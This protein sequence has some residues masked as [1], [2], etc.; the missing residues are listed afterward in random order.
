MRVVRVHEFGTP[1]VL[2][3]EQAQVPH[4]AAGQVVIA[5]ELAGVIYGDVIVR[6]GRYPFPL[7]YVPGLEVGGRVIEVGADVDPS[8]VGQ[9]VVATTVGM[10]GGYAELAVADTANVHQ[11]P[12]SLPLEHAVAVFQ[13]GGLSVGILSAMQVR[14]EDTV[15]VTAA[16]G[17][18]GSVLVQLAKAA[19]AK[20]V[21]AAGG[22]EKVVAA[23]SRFGADTAVDYSEPDWV[24]QV[25]AATGGRGADVVLDAIGGTIGAQ[26][27]DAVRNGSGRI[28]IY[29]FT[30]GSW[31]ALDAFQL[32]RRGLTVVGALGIAFAKPT[33]EQR[34]D[35]EQA[36]QAASAGQLLPHIHGIYPLEQ[37]A[38]AQSA[39]G[40]RGTIGAVLLRP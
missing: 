18:I 4:P 28:G 16:A 34:A 37:A 6:S 15:L 1:D 23:A 10:T 22:E 14:A 35:A 26:A 27:L 32:G 30:S 25:M 33:A 31:T 2:T 13:A 17:R 29:G 21:G 5:V 40:E 8:L 38:E 24:D 9:L 7:P 3:L 12:E 20:V 11:V 19:G 36:L 39:L